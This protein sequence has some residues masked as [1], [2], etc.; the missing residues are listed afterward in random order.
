MRNI[1]KSIQKKKTSPIRKM[2]LHTPCG[3][4]RKRACVA[5]L[6]KM[7]DEKL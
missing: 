1:K 2:K 7:K 4:D 6:R 5:D 3:W